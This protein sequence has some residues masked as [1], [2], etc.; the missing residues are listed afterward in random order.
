VA[1]A[2]TGKRGA[3][4]AGGSKGA[5]VGCKLQG[6]RRKLQAQDKS[7]HPVQRSMHTQG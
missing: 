3:G 5:V 7:E 2:R 6:M 4:K 1:T